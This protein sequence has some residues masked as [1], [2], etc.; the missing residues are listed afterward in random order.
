MEIG[1]V[2][3]G[4]TGR[5]IAKMV[6]KS[7]LRVRLV[8]IDSRAL[9]LAVEIIHKDLH[10]LV[11]AGEMTNYEKDILLQNIKTSTDY[12]DL[13]DCSIILEFLPEDLEL[14]K[15]VIK[16][17]DKASPSG[18]IVTG[19]S[20]LSINKIASAAK[21][22]QRIIG[23]HFTHRPTEISVVEIIPG[24]KTSP[25]TLKKVQEFCAHL[26]QEVIM[27]TDIPGFIYN[28]LVFGIINEA[29]NMI[30]KKMATAESVDSVMRIG[31]GLPQGPLALADDIGLDYIHAVLTNMFAATKDKCFKPAAG[32]AKLVRAKQF[33]KKSGQGFYKY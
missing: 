21:K 11:A 30:D 18:I 15:R 3:A 13:A 16:L 8:D 4:F 19:T 24:R 25:A 29:A 26:K 5:A 23:L 9:L 27:A 7:G 10:R 17:V 1:I 12:G 14:K 20:S 31:M 33:G 32:I 6:A 28:R 22:P 2:G